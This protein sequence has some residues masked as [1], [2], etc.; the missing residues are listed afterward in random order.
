MFPIRLTRLLIEPVTLASPVKEPTTGERREKL[1]VALEL[2]AMLPVIGTVRTGGTTTP[3]VSEA[4]FL[5]VGQDD[6]TG[7]NASPKL[8]RQYTIQP[9]QS[10]RLKMRTS[11]IKLYRAYE[12]SPFLNDNIWLR[13]KEGSIFVRR[14]KR[15]IE[16]GRRTTLDIAN[17]NIKPLEQGKGV[18]TKFLSEVEKNTLREAVFI[19]NVLDTRFANFF[20][21]NGYKILTEDDHFGVC[22]YKVIMKPE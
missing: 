6:I 14:T 1:P 5:K 17:I 15:I 7:M 2:R 11:L 19:E 10:R 20:I 8:G 13:G 22:F 21:K 16:G 12:A 4:T 18:F 9:K 3:S